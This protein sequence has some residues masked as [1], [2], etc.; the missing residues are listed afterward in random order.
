[1]SL[2]IGVAP[3]ELEVLSDESCF[4]SASS[5]FSL[6]F[7]GR[8]VFAVF[9]ERTKEEYILLVQKRRAILEKKPGGSRDN[10]NNP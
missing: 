1:L 9:R 2:Q 6:L 10:P 3:Y 7:I 4:V 8:I 5:F